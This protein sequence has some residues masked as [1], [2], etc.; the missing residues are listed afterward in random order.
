MA[1]TDGAG[2]DLLS[3]RG[4]TKQWD[5]TGD[6]VLDDVDLTAPRGGVVFVGGQNGVGKTTLLRIICGLIAPEAGTIAMAGLDPRRDRR[7]YQAALGFL[8]AG[9]S[10]LY[11]RLT[12]GQHMDYWSRLAFMTGAP[13]LEAIRSTQTAFA[14]DELA[15]RRVDRLSMGQR[16]RL[17]LAVTFL[18]SPQLV[19][20]DEPLNSLDDEGAA[21]LGSALGALGGRGG[22]AIVCSPSEQTVGDVRFDRSYTLIGGRLEAE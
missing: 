17:R 22:A 20:L 9:N 5:P 10:G 11:A 8:S 12:V 14:L 15:D 21:V 7:A 13:R 6:P 16:Q 3:V 19:L 2:Q 1:G 4:V 18:H